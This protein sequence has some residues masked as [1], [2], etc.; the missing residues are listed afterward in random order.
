[1]RTKKLTL[2]SLLLAAALVLGFF[3][4]LIPAFAVVPGGKIGLANIVTM[5][6]FCLF[7]LPE[8]LLFGTVRSLLTAVLYS[9]ISA[10]FYSC[11]GSLLSVLAM[12]IFRKILK[13][14]ISEIGL[15]VLGAVWFNIGQLAVAALVLGTVQIFRY[16]PALGIVAAVAGLLTGYVTK[17]LIVYITRK[18]IQNNTEI[19]NGEHDLWK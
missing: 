3:E 16:F 7:S 15:S 12:W 8:A 19:Q 14:R 11:A 6:V 1:M 18:N 4:S 10:F 17:T 13:N 9:G 5:T 2:F